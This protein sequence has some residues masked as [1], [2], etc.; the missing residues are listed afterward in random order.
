MLK[1]VF[2][3]LEDGVGCVLIKFIDT[4]S[5]RAA[6]ESANSTEIQNQPGKSACGFQ[7]STPMAQG[8]FGPTGERPE[9]SSEN[10]QGPRK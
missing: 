1:V 10:H 5:G 9:E 3:S 4:D 2:V 7:V 8:R 6:G